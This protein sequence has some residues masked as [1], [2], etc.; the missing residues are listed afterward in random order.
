MAGSVNTDG[1]CKGVPYSDNFGDYGDS[2]VA[3]AT[4]KITLQD[5]LATVNLDSNKIH[6]RNGCS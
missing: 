2:A 6:M 3:Q 5:Y 1:D 4:I